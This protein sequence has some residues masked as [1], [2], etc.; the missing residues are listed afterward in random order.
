[1]LVRSTSRT[2][3]SQVLP[4]IVITGALAWINSRHLRVILRLGVGAHGRAEGGDAGVLQVQLVLRPLEELHVL[5][6]GA[7]PAALDVIHAEL[8]QT[9]GNAQLVVTA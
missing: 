5:R 9:A 1:M 3:R 2:C 4:K 8:V 6:I 7:G